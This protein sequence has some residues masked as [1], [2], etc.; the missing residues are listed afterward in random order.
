MCHSIF[1]I[2]HDLI[3]RDDAART[4]ERPEKLTEIRQ[5]QKRA[6]APKPDAAAPAP[7]FAP[8]YAPPLAL[9]GPAGGPRPTPPATTA[10]ARA[11][12]KS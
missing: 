10:P 12:A 3:D 11:T 2:R 4:A 7:I 6:N 8:A 1:D 5:E 9:H